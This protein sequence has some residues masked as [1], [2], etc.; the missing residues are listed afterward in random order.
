MQTLEYF[1]S[2]YGNRYITVMHR[3]RTWYN[4]QAKKA[5]HE[6]ETDRVFRMNSYAASLTEKINTVKQKKGK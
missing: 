5:A 4:Q 1:K 6:H 3:M 2:T